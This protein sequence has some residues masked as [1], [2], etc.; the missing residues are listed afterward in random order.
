MP[1]TEQATVL[2]AMALAKILITKEISVHLAKEAENALLLLLVSRK[3]TI[4]KR[5]RSIRISFVD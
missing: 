5:I 3:A 2:S 4:N 1:A